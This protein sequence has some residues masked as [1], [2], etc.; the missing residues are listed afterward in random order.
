MQDRLPSENSLPSTSLDVTGFRTAKPP[1]EMVYRSLTVAA[2]VL[3]LV[4]LWVF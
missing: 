3:L 4:S 2:I 1:E